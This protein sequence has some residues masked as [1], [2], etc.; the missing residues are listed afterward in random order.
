MLADKGLVALLTLPGTTVNATY[1]YNLAPLSFIAAEAYCTD[2]GGHLVSYGSLVRG[3]QRG[4]RC[5]EL[6]RCIHD[7]CL[8]SLARNGSPWECASVVSF[9][10]ASLLPFN[11]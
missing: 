5:A 4:A 9:T 10:V 2:R 8:C 11:P 7:H 6:W 3:R 1:F